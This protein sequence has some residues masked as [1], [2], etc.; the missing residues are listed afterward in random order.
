VS[1]TNSSK[2]K[3]TYVRERGTERW[4]LIEC[5]LPIGQIMKLNKGRVDHALVFLA[6][7]IRVTELHTTDVS[8]LPSDVSTIHNT[9]PP[10]R[11]SPKKK[12][13]PLQRM[14]VMEPIPPPP[15][16]SPRDP[17][18]LRTKAP[19]MVPQEKAKAK[20][21]TSGAARGSIGQTGGSRPR[22]SPAAP[23]ARTDPQPFLKERR[24]KLFAE[25]Q[26]YFRRAKDLLD[27][28]E[29]QSREGHQ[30][31]KEDYEK[32]AEELLKKADEEFAKLEQYDRTHGTGPQRSSGS[33]DREEPPASWR[34]GAKPK[35]WALCAVVEDD[36]SSS[37]EELVLYGQMGRHSADIQESCFAGVSGSTRCPYFRSSLG[38]RLAS[39]IPNA[40]SKIYGDNL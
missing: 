38:I 27:A 6:E 23:P 18:E 40:T 30:A 8:M 35:T 16:D 21:S 10:A 24:E 25:G 3:F 14:P 31:T 32:K 36:P 39:R 4:S 2:H 22:A 9:G 13:R 34:R 17:M 15:M 12:A 37:E 29:T 7:P 33:G 11:E 1:D 28:A 5:D 26:A 20:G 19:P